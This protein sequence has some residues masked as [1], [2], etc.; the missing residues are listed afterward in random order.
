MSVR[1]ILFFSCWLSSSLVA[2]ACGEPEV[3]PTIAKAVSTQSEHKK[4]AEALAA[5]EK[6]ER[7]AAAKAR[8]ELEERR[9]TEIEEVAQLP[10]E[11]PKDV[12][13]ACDAVTAAYDEFMK[14]G[15]EKDVLA[16][17]DGRRKSLGRRRTHCITVGNPS[18]AACEAEA[19]RHEL[20]SLSDLPRV[21]AARMVMERCLEKFGE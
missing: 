3:D 10:A 7:E 14:R 19:L 13:S 17:H 16:W 21:D 18:V 11:M 4:A 12:G 2:S 15:S 8:R 1:T 20:P 5:K 9:R 6:A